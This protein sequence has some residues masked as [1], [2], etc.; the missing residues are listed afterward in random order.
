MEKVDIV[1]FI[2]LKFL[3]DTEKC[4]IKPNLHLQTY[5]EGYVVY[6]P[7]HFS[8]D[9]LA[10]LEQILLHRSNSGF[11]M[12]STPF[13]IQVFRYPIAQPIRPAVFQQLA[14]FGANRSMELSKFVI[15]CFCRD[16][17]SNWSGN[18]VQIV[19]VVLR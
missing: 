1:I 14:G 5:C 9:Q 12:R 4:Y 2:S 11:T 10:Q 16:L 8:S 6:I 19:L 7:S 17:F 18:P 15:Q 3:S 13:V